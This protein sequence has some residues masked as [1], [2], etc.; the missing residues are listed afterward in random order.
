MAITFLTTSFI[1]ITTVYSQNIGIGTINP[2]SKPHVEGKVKIDANNSIE[3]GA[4]V[5]GKESNAGKIS[6]Q[7]FIS[8]AL[9]I[10]GAGST[11]TNRIIKFWN[12]GG[13]EFISNVGIG[14]SNTRARLTVL[15]SLINSA[16]NTEVK[17]VA[18]KNIMLLFSDINGGDY[19]CIKAIS[20]LTPTP[21]FSR[22]GIEVSAAGNDI[23]FSSAGYQPALMKRNLPQ[24]RNWYQ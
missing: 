14:L 8:G 19:A 13:A 7:T 10:V 6:Y 1:F 3:I 17:Q 11:G 21:R 20:D 9:D 5:V 18:G 16:S 4:G 12:E 23:Y 22:C 24:C 15:S 2:L